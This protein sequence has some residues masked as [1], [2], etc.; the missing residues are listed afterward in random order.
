MEQST[1]QQKLG[2]VV[3]KEL[4]E[5]FQ[6]E[7]KEHFPNIMI[8]V[9]K[10]N[11]TRDL[12]IARVYLS[13]FGVEDKSEAVE[14]VRLHA[15]EI[16]YRLGNRIAKQVRMVPQLEFYEDDSLDY[17]ENIERLLDDD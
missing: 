3:Q 12:S 8:T 1:R 14:N 6:F 17:I 11:V 9:T 5:I 4:G 16:R 10:V 13:I 15:G 7:T 2:R